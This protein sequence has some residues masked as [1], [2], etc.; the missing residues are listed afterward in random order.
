MRI[1]DV[2]ATL[3]KL[4][5]D[6]QLD[7][8][9]HPKPI[10]EVV[11]VEI[12]TD[13]GV[14]GSGYTYTDGYGGEAIRALL[15]PT[16]RELVL[17]TDPTAVEP[18]VTG[19]YWKLRKIGYGG[20]VSLAIAGFDIAAW[21]IISKVRGKPLVDLFGSFKEDM[22]VYSSAIGSRMFDVNKQIEMAQELVREDYVGVKIQLGRPDGDE[23]VERIRRVREALG[24]KTI[25]IVD[26]NTLWNADQAISVGRRILEFKPYYMEEP[27]P[28]HD[29]EGHEKISRTLPIPIATGEAIFD[30]RGCAEYIRRRAVSYIQP[31]VCRIGGIT[32]WK[33]VATLAESA[34][35]KVAPHFVAEL[36]VQLACT[37]P[38][39]LII[40]HVPWLI[41]HL[42]EPP[43]LKGGKIFPR[44]QPGLGM[45]FLPEAIQKY[46][47]DR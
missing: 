45:E 24:D 43:T 12:E 5:W 35:M 9:A 26:S 32:Q 20:A 1:T 2:K 15:V 18:I 36:H 10:V 11:V 38:N 13:E 8:R 7:P 31:N 22:P 19:L 4:P 25:I 14:T 34:N 37:I 27:I 6:Q 3:L 33:K 16:I 23:D 41:Q 40:E 28:P 17:G 39:A 47:A 29:I 46:R 42:K 44:R 21:D 30:Y